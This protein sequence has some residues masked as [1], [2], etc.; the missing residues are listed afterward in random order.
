MG[1]VRW[2]KLSRLLPFVLAVAMPPTEAQRTKVTP[3]ASK[4]AIRSVARESRNPT[5][6]RARKLCKN[7]EE[8]QGRQHLIRFLETH[9]RSGLGWYEFANCMLGF[10][11]SEPP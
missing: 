1:H 7:G 9:P 5:L 11:G 4:A 6:I 8:E 10:K 2:H 3:P